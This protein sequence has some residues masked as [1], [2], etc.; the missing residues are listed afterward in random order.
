MG[1]GVEGE[2]VTLRTVLSVK[3]FYVL[4]VIHSAEVFPGFFSI[5]KL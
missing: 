4:I 5:F 3:L 2:G 1:V